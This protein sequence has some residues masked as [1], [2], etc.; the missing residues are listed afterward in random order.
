MNKDKKCLIIKEALKYEPDLK[1]IIDKITDKQL[2]DL[3]KRTNK[4]KI[5]SK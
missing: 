1:Y 3:E 4:I 5:R 2:I